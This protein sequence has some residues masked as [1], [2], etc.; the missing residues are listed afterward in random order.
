MT[1][2]LKSSAGQFTELQWF[3]HTVL[4]S[5]GLVSDDSLGDQL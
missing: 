5:A 2:W 1:G 4:Q 3:A